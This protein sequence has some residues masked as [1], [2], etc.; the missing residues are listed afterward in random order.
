M[1]GFTSRNAWGCWD[2]G[3]LTWPGRFWGAQ[4]G[5]RLRSWPCLLLSEGRHFIYTSTCLY[6]YIYHAA[7]LFVKTVVTDAVNNFFRNSHLS[8]YILIRMNP[9]DCNVRSFHPSH[10]FSL[11]GLVLFLFFFLWAT[12]AAYGGSQARG[13]IGDT[14]A[15]L[16]HSNTG[17]KLHL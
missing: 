6:L 10:H 9:L 17:S 7:L 15:G 4:D 14:A 11:S 13:Q 3:C 16:H 12:G 8:A 1:S 2:A 5:V